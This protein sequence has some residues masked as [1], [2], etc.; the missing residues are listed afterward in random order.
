MQLARVDGNVVATIAHPSMRG[1]RTLICQP[2]SETGEAIGQPVLALDTLGA[3]LHSKVFMTT[4]GSY[5]QEVV[6]DKT[7]PIRN[8]ILGIVDESKN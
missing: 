2:I 5:A 6:Q 8:S 1:C 7:S 4:D 3:G